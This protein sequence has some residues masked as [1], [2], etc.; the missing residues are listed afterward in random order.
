M[1]T[2]VDTRRSIGAS[3]KC[4]ISWI[5]YQNTRRKTRAKPGRPGVAD[6]R[7]GSWFGRSDRKRLHKSGFSSV[8]RTVGGEGSVKEEELK[9]EIGSKG[10]KEG[11][12]I[13]H[14]LQ[15]YTFH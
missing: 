6:D 4:A 1:N 11:W 14:E 15:G 12:G 9:M 10:V 5:N 8:G 13:Y 2:L 7:S 3:G